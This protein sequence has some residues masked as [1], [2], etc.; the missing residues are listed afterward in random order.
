MT[1]GSL[2]GLIFLVLLAI[3]IVYSYILHYHWREYSMN[4]T[5]TRR[6]YIT[7][8]ATTL[9]LLLLMGLSVLISL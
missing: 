6:T 5:V 3:Y 1:T 9:P 2:L 8:A 4:T 7:Y